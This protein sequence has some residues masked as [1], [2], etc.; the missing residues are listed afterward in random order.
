MKFWKMNGAGNDFILINNIEEKLPAEVFPDLARTLCTRRLSIGADGMMIVEK[1]TMG[2]DL[3]MLFFNSDGSVGE[4]C[5]NGARCI[6]RYAVE[7]G[8]SEGSRQ[9]IETTAGIVT[10]QRLDERNFRIRLN[11]PSVIE[12]SHPL[13]VDGETYEAYYVV[14]GDPGIPHA[15][16]PIRDL[17]GFDKDRLRETGRKMRFHESF[18]K[19]ANVN[20]F[21]IQE[22]GEILEYTY[23]RGVEDFTY[24]CGT[25]TGSVGAALAVRAAGCGNACEGTEGSPADR[26]APAA[27]TIRREG[28]LV[29]HSFVLHMAG[30]T[31]TVDVVLE[32]KTV[33]DLYLSGPTNIVAT[34]EIR[35]EELVLKGKEEG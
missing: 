8:F 11:D 2:G 9:V 19:G 14:L 33:K 24:A 35:D 15:C 13:T 4:M 1:P 17:A 18:P 5:G 25:G 12:T 7:S 30:G 20:F 27:G 16:V 31:L 21:E 26:K 29:T 23:E 28:D 10:G 34:G 6:C 3:K 32:G 22:N